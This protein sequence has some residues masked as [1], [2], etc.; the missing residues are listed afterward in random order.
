M[1]TSEP[2]GGSPLETFSAATRV[3]F[4]EGSAPWL[5]GITSLIGELEAR[6]SLEPAGA[7]AD[8]ARYLVDADRDGE[9]LELEL[10]Y[11]DGW[12][13]ETTRALDA[14][15]GDGTLRLF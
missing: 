5:E 7:R 12:W 15:R 3:R 10:S 14:W 2:G 6:W 1:S 8:D 13:A 9:P 11:P 4:G